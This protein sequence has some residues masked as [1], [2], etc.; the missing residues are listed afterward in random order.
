M[1]VNFLVIY[2]VEL[3]IK[4]QRENNTE[5][6]FNSRFL[7]LIIVNIIIFCSENCIWY[8]NC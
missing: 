4:S 7:Y 5:K 2:K 1:V 6:V 8:K 3:E